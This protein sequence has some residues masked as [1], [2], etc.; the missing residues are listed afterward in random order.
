MLPVSPPRPSTSLRM[1]LPHLRSSRRR[2]G[3]LAILDRSPRMRSRVKP[4]MSGSEYRGDVCLGSLA[5]IR[6]PR[7]SLRC[8]PDAYAPKNGLNKTQRPIRRFNESSFN[9]HIIAQGVNALRSHKK[10]YKFSS[11]EL[12]VHIHSMD[13]LE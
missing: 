11:I 10:Y 8:L 12:H 2:P 6:L 4:G 5:D 13:L 7:V 1:R 3:S 9:D